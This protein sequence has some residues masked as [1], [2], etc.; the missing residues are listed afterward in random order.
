VLNVFPEL[1][2]L[3]ELLE[4]ELAELDEFEVDDECDA[5]LVELEADDAVDEWWLDDA[6]A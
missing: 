5:A 2:E 4:L 1:V 3:P 6:A